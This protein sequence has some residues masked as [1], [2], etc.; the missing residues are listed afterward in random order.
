MEERRYTERW[1]ATSLMHTVARL[2]RPSLYA[3]MAYV[4]SSM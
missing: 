4:I 1:D 3:L 2:L